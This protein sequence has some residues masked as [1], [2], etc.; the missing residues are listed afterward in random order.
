M[1][2]RESPGLARPLAILMG[3]TLASQ[4]ASVAYTSEKDFLAI[5]GPSTLMLLVVTAPLALL[6]LRLGPSL[7][8]G[9]PLLNALL[10]R[11]PGAFAQLGRDA[12]LATGIGL[13]IGAFLWGL[14]PVLLPY[15]PP[16][17]PELG[18]RGAVGGLLVSISA[19]IGEETWFRLG[20]MTLLA[21]LIKRVSGHAELRPA[22]A[23]A[24]ILLSA[25]PFG[26]IHLPQLAAAGAASQGAVA[27]TMFG[28]ML[29]A[30]AYGWLYWKR[31]LVAAIVAHFAVDVV[32]HV[33]PALA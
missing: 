32:L 14:R 4:L 25:I 24:A 1:S 27:A 13:A 23:W 29:V 30:V 26:L 28:N 2:S 11:R 19:A 22:A 9:A 21:W 18:H 12:L 3:L 20:V 5:V 7:G 6:G 8:L 16:E 17:L 15:L 33:L 10:D 31:S